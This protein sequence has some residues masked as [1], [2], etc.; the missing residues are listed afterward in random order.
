M[1]TA[2]AKK[3]RDRYVCPNYARISN[4]FLSGKKGANKKNK[5]VRVEKK[6]MENRALQERKMDLCKTRARVLCVS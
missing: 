6:G 1:S 5:I 2:D 3:K 4:I